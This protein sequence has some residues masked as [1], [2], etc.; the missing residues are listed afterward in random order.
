MAKTTHQ[1]SLQEIEA[2]RSGQYGILFYNGTSIQNGAWLKLYVT[3]AA[4]FSAIAITDMT[5]AMTGISFPAGTIIEG[6]ITSFTLSAGSVLAYYSP[7][8]S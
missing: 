7:A 2:C 5:G 8:M 6:K 1:L 4:T 3:A